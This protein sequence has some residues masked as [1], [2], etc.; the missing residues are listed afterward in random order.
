MK[1]SNSFLI[2]KKL[3]KRQ[4][5]GNLLKEKISQIEIKKNPII[6]KFPK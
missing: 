5:L 4:L 6:G 3:I 2:N 1:R